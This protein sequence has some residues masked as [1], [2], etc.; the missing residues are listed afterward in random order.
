MR[1]SVIIPT[2]NGAGK[3]LNILH[4]LEQQ[5]RQPD[6]VIVV[7]DGSTDNTADLLR[8]QRP[9]VPGL[10]IVEQKNKGRA[11]VRNRGAAEA[12]GDLLVFFDDDMIVPEHTLQAHAAHHITYPGGLMCGRLESPHKDTRDDFL[13]FQN[14]LNNR[15]Q[16]GYSNSS[17]AVVKLTNPYLT[18]CNFSVTPQVFNLLGRFDERLNDL[19]DY[20]LAHR[21]F[22]HHYPIYINNDAWAYHNDTGSLNIRNYLKRLRQ[23]KQAQDKLILLKPD[24]FTDPERNERL[25]EKPRGLKGYIFHFFANDF[26]ID[27]IDKGR[28]KWI[29]SGIRYKLY[30][31]I[32]TANSV[33]FPEKIRL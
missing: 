1:I 15:W 17:E 21:A 18:A 28:M 3:I 2:Y 25:V 10:K 22:Q 31:I 11:A 19:E 8:Q 9:A 6:E 13:L 4:S 24:I 27:S 30:D 32:V 16:K 7:I 20:E 14:W 26:W 12:A 23:Y 5:T 33:M 29:P